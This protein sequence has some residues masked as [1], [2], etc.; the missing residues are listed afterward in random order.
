MVVKKS[1]RAGLTVFAFGVILQLISWF[2]MSRVTFRRIPIGGEPLHYVDE[3][4]YPYLGLWLSSFFLSVC[5]IAVSIIAIVRAK[6]TAR[7]LPTEE[8][9]TT[10]ITLGD[11]RPIGWCYCEKHKRRY[12]CENGCPECAREL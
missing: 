11:G 2:F 8:K 4:S 12:L 3:P 7:A 5:I 1:R 9:E 6:K 10:W